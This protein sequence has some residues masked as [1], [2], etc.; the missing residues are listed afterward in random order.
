MLNGLPADSVVLGGMTDRLLPIWELRVFRA[1]YLTLFLVLVASGA[2][3]PVPEEVT[4]V[5]AGIMS[6]NGAL[7]P[8]LALATCL[9][10]ALIGDSVMYWIG[11]HFGRGILRRSRW[12][13]HIASPEREERMETLIQQHGLKVFFLARFLVGL[14]SPVYLSAGVLH[15]PLRRFLLI[16]L[17]SATVVVSLFF[18]LSY[19]FGPMVREWI[20][21]VE[22]S[23]TA[24]VVV[25]AAVAF[26]LWRRRRSRQPSAASRPRTTKSP[27]AAPDVD[28]ERAGRIASPRMVF[29]KVETPAQQPVEP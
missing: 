2:G 12:W 15:I 23:A 16:D 19:T 29:P 21:G 9:L 3:L 4:V 14:R 10:G 25:V 5:A 18:G 1:S 22:Y 6:A 24:V 27:P 26:L 11:F 28:P 8:W 17:L 20:R 7:E 13:R